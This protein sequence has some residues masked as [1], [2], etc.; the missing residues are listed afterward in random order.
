M[1][2]I[3]IF[4]KKEYF[5]FFLFHLFIIISTIIIYDYIR[6]TLF[7]KI[8]MLSFILLSFY[9]IYCIFLESSFE[10]KS[11][12]ILQIKLSEKLCLISFIGLVSVIFT[13]CFEYLCLKFY[14]EYIIKCPFLLQNFD[15]KIHAQRRCELYNINSTNIF[16]YQYICSFNANYDDRK[17]S[18]VEKLIENN[19]I[20]DSFIKEYYKELNLYYCD[21]KKQPKF[22]KKVKPELCDSKL[23]NYFLI[24][25]IILNCYFFIRC[26]IIIYYHFRLIIPNI[27]LYEN[28]HLF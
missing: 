21:L 26:I 17:C 2:I 9:F 18:K 22:P 15:Y 1:E 8:L 12:Q 3:N 27:N 13:F 19:E 20:I 16:P 28:L 7:F 10:Y 5:I 23:K 11:L 25:S 24:I 4:R 14:Y 6:N